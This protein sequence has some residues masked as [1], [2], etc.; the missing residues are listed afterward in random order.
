MECEQRAQ[1]RDHAKA[2]F[3]T[4]ALGSPVSLKMCQQKKKKKLLK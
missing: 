1:G 4:I 2:Y 3:E